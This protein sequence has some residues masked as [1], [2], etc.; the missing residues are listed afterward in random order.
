MH[1]SPSSSFPCRSHQLGFFYDR[2]VRAR[3]TVDWTLLIGG[4]LALAALVG[5]DLYPGS[6]VGVPGE[7]SNMA[8]P[9]VCIVA[10]VLLQAGMLEII[11][12]AIQLR[13]ERPTWEWVSDVINRFALPLFLFQAVQ[14]A[15]Q[16]A[17]L[18]LVVVGVS[19]SHLHQRRHSSCPRPRAA[20]ATRFVR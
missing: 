10:L 1:P 9:T 20:A 11:R 6:M 14:L 12:P 15:E 7:T 16:P 3:R 13:L 8:P 18:R 5:A 19:I 17:I 4:A 2:I